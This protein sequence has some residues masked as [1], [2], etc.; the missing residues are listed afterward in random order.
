MIDHFQKFSLYNQWANNRLYEAVATLTTE[1]Q[2]RDLSGFF[3]NILG[4]LNHILVGDLYWMERIEGAGPRPASL[5]EILYPDFGELRTARSASDE[6]LIRITNA[7]GQEEY[8]AYLDY[9]TTQGVACHDQKSE[10]FAHLFNHQTHH[11]GQC[12]HM[13]T[14]LGKTLPPLDM[15]YFFRERE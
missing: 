10:V 8:S 4:T 13:L 7:Q 9:V 11:R 15:I 2:T 14:Q 1:E 5:D 3:G 6:R 12:H